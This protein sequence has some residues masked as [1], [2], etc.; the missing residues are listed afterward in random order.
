MERN[1]PHGIYGDLDHNEELGL[2]PRLLG[3]FANFEHFTPGVENRIS[4]RHGEASSLRDS[5]GTL[6]QSAHEDKSWAR[7]LLRRALDYG[8]WDSASE[9]LI[10]TKLVKPSTLKL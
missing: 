7:R 8:V 5:S 9:F 1:L 6:R 4:D 3:V 2:S 10:N